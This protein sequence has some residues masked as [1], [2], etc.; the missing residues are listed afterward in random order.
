MKHRSRL[1]ALLMALPLCALAWFLWTNIE[2][3][4]TQVAVPLGEDALRNPFYAA[5]RLTR[6]LG[7][8]VQWRRVLGELPSTDAAIVLGSWHWSLIDSRRQALE[9]WV[10]AGGRLVVTASLIDGGPFAAWSGVRAVDPEE[11]KAETDTNKTAPAE[12]SGLPAWLRNDE[13]CEIMA[14]DGK[15]P[16]K[17]PANSSWNVC[18]YH[19]HSAL[20]SETRPLWS[21]ENAQGLQL[22]SVRKGRGRVTVVNLNPFSYR[23]LLRGQNARLLAAALALGERDTVLFLSANEATSLLALM[24]RYGAPTILLLLATLALW[25][26]RGGVRF[27]PPLAVA[28]TA[29]RS[30]A[31]QIV[32]TSRFLY[33]HG[34]AA[35]LHAAVRKSVERLAA[36]RAPGFRGMTDDARID[37]VA[38]ATGIDYRR[39]HA[40]MT[41]TPDTRQPDLPTALMCLEACRRIMTGALRQR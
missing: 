24:W 20:Q 19:A 17:P 7:A 38:R 2:M 27:G 12:S 41:W 30:L 39:V 10:E 26:W 4:A 11:S 1:I 28:N 18:G 8:Q 36:L 31:E 9:R 3:R 37:A 23:E 6:E 32:G 33:H 14:A 13:R 25:L 5:T 16:V 40:A 34:G 21:L 35:S 22:V 15:V 29:R